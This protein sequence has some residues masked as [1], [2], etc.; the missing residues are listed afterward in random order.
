MWSWDVSQWPESI[1]VYKG[2]PIVLHCSF[3]H[4]AFPPSAATFR[5]FWKNVIIYEFKTIGGIKENNLT[6][7]GNPR[8]SLKTNLS[9]SSHLTINDVTFEDSALYSCAVTIHSPLPITRRNGNGTLVNVVE[10]PFTGQCQ[11]NLHKVVMDICRITSLRRPSI[12]SL[13]LSFS[14]PAPPSVFK[15][16]KTL[17]YSRCNSKLLGPDA[18]SMPGPPKPHVSFIA[19]DTSI[20]WRHHQEPGSDCDSNLGTPYGYA[21]VCSTWVDSRGIG[22]HWHCFPPIIHGIIFGDEQNRASRFI[23]LLVLEGLLVL[24]WL[25]S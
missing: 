13:A 17:T 19:V 3:T 20:W 11:S 22:Q 12:S 24:Q 7:L 15:E 10:R 4:H 2:D 9:G 1:H 5:W 16:P 8:M 18:K 23:V 21:P 25:P 6:N 14:P